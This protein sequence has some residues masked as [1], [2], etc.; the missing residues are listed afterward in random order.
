MK[1]HVKYDARAARHALGGNHELA[2]KATYRALDRTIDTGRAESAR[3][4]SSR[5]AVSAATVRDAIDKKTPNASSGVGYIV[6]RGA[7]LPLSMFPHAPMTSGTGGRGKPPLTIEVV[8]GERRPLR[9]AFVAETGGQLRVMARRGRERTP[10]RELST[11]PIPVMLGMI[12]P[13]LM[14]HL[15]RAFAIRLQHEITRLGG[16]KA[17]L[18]R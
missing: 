17:T 14:P 2:W 9:G 4:I 13:D 3:L 1:L 15:S 10:I 8:R 5:Y 11:V 18:P 7:K 12:E 6:S 16:G